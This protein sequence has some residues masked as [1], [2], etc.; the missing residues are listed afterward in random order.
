MLLVAASSVAQEKNQATL[1][2]QGQ[3]EIKTNPD[4]IRVNVKLSAKDLKYRQAVRDLDNKVKSLQK[5]L[6]KAGFEEDQ[7]NTQ[8]L[9]VSVNRIWGERTY[10][11]SGFVARQELTLVFP[12][13]AE[14]LMEAINAISRSESNPEYHLNF[15]LSDESRKKMRNQL[16]EEAIADARE[17]AE[18]ITKAA[19]TRITGIHSINYNAGNPVAY[20]MQKVM[21]ESQARQQSDYSAEI[22][23]EEIT[24]SDQIT[25][26]WKIE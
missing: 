1:S 14:K 22:N 10:Q 8:N 18:I 16:I 25:I 13:Q 9:N 24:L 2:I 6:L 21:F 23:P 11:D 5:A 7:L 15:S 20:P 4:Q 26:V 3:G 19:G 12:Y 17:K